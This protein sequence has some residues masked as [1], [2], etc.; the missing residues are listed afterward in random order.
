MTAEKRMAAAEGRSPIQRIGMAMREAKGDGFIVAT[1]DKMQTWASENETH[2]NQ[3]RAARARD[4]AHS[5][6]NWP[7]RPY[8]TPE[9]LTVML[10]E[11]ASML[12]Y[13]G[14]GFNGNVAGK[15]SRD[16]RSVQIPYLLNNDHPEGFMYRG[17]R[18]QFLV[19]AAFDDYAQPMTQADFDRMAREWPTYGQLRLQ[20]SDP[21]AQ[22]LQV[23]HGGKKG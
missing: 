22:K 16:L 14:K 4:I 18:Q 19:V 2:P 7:I 17:T 1:L 9:E 5:I 12:G 10:P 23:S 21:R 3:E 20:S 15:I 8:Y 6:L 13:A 11:I